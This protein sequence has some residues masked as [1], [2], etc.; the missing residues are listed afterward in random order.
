MSK[1]IY[2]GR[3][4]RALRMRL[5][6][7]QAELAKR[8]DISSTYVNLIE[9]DRRPVTSGLL[10]EL[11]RVLDV[12]LRALASGADAELLAA[13]TE[14]FS[15]PVFE[16]HPLTGQDLTAFVEGS[17]EVARAVVWLHQAY[18]GS[19]RSLEALGERLLDFQHDIGSDLGGV[20]RAR[21]SSEQ[22]SDF[23]QRHQ[24]HFPAL[25]GEAE[26][27]LAESRGDDDGDDLFLR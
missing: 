11:A 2:L 18:A 7:S 20:E 3:R 8:L 1:P 17:P 5:R 16:D 9:H 6:I 13:L 19:R 27:L 4:I 24:N 12:D 22:V 10:L 14:V 15:D 21:L 23:I 25:E 26:R